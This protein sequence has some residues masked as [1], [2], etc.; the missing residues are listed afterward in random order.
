MNLLYLI[1]P[2]CLLTVTL[3]FQFAAIGPTTQDAMTAEGLCVSCAAQKPTAEHLAA[4]IA[5]ALQ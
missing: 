3:C 5:K 1:V 2:R 4:A